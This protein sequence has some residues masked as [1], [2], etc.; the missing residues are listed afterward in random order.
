MR[1][2]TTRIDNTVFGYQAPPDTPALHR[3]VYKWIQSLDMS[4]A[5]KNP[6]RD[7]QNGFLVAEIFS[8]Y[9][10]SDIQMHSF[11][12][13]T[14]THYKRDNWSQLQRFCTKQGLQLPEELV[15]GTIQGVHGAAEAMLEHLYEIFTNRKL[16]RL[17]ASQALDVPQAPVP[18]QFTFGEAPGNDGG[19]SGPGPRLISSSVR[20]PQGLEFGEVQTK[21]AGDAIAL[22]KK[23]AAQGS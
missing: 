16:P 2:T 14:S 15:E 18:S 6:R 4:H 9:F 5:L 20:G 13:A 21:G 22:R 17:S 7:C 23:L 3:D 12:N 10:P 19:A 1:A 11:L 8:R